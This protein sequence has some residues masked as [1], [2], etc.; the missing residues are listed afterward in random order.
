MGGGWI[1]RW[2]IIEVGGLGGGSSLR[3]VVG[4]LGDGSSLRWVGLEVG[5]H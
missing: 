5:H 4:G 1:G 3:R 2:V